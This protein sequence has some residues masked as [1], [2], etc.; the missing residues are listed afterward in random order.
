M[1]D[2][3]LVF[4]NDELINE[5]NKTFIENI[6]LF[7]DVLKQF[8]DLGIGEIT[9]KEDLIA[10]IGQPEAFLLTKVTEYIA[11]SEQPTFGGFKIQP[12]KLLE[13]LN[14]K[15]RGEF[16]AACKEAKYYVGYLVN[17]GEV[18]KGRVVS[19]PKLVELFI[20]NNTILAITDKEKTVFAAMNRVKEG[21]QMLFDVQVIP[22]NNWAM[23]L[24]AFLEKP[25]NRDT[26]KLNIHS[27]KIFAK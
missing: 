25:D 19:D 3:N 10:A 17:I 7:E 14:L 23:N 20:K 16:I 5:T 22:Y 27:Y 26:F 11:T 2:Q 9:N 8:A 13:M 15:E 21:L 12:E 24:N 6:P 1:S 4:R 18:K